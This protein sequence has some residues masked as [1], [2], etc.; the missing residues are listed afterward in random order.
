M[1]AVLARPVAASAAEIKVWTARAIATVLAEVGAEFER[2]TGHT[3]VI[4][5]DLPPAFLRRVNAGEPF[6]VL[7]SGSSP[8]DEWIRDGRIVAETRTNIARSGI[9]VEVRAGGR[10]PDISSV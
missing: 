3:L 2:A 4:S 1:A 10:K 9:G 5:S 6:D 8:V 7:I